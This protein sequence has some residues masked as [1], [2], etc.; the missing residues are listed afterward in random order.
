MRNIENAKGKGRKRKTG[1]GKGA[2]APIREYK[3][4]SPEP[5]VPKY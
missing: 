3:E 2:L 5:T 1:S 4:V